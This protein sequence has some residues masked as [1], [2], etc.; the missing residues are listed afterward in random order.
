MAAKIAPAPRRARPRSEID[1]APDRRR[2]ILMAAEALFARHGYH[3]VSIRDIAEKA[4]VPLA[5]VGYYYGP[6]LALYEEIFR[7][8]SGYIRERL[9]ALETLWHA[10]P[11]D[12]LL[13]RIVR[14]FVRPALKL[15]ANPEGRQFM[16]LV[17]RN[18][19]EQGPENS[20]PRAELFDPVAHAYI[21]ALMKALPGISRA[22]AAWCY[23][24][25]LG[26]L[27]H[28]ISDQ[29][30]ED[31]SHGQAKAREFDRSADLLCRFLSAGIRHACAV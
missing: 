21:D 4:G 22:Q 19:V 14:A 9:A 20:G 28:H 6:K 3:G 10:G 2:N 29:R 11:P 30:I 18:L 31:L 5:L 25:S 12:E 8:R 23:Q 16:Q 1:E 27:M 26:A 17:A 24:F 13:D 15:A 7:Q